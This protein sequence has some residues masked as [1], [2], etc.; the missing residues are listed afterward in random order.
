MRE[1]LGQVQ[2]TAFRPG[3]VLAC[4]HEFD[5]TQFFVGS[6]FLRGPGGLEAV[7]RS[8][9]YWPR[10]IIHEPAHTPRSARGVSQQPEQRHAFTIMHVPSQS[11]LVDTFAAHGR[12]RPRKSSNSGVRLPKL[13]LA[14]H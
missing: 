11:E 5:P 13:P 8:F 6:E 10:P 3:V 2:A 4:L 1:W 14:K 12:P 7:L 9:V